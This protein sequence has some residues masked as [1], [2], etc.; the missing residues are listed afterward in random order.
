MAA[1]HLNVLLTDLKMLVKIS[2]LYSLFFCMHTGN[3]PFLKWNLYHQG[4]HIIDNKYLRPCL[5]DN[6]QHPNHPSSFNTLAEFV[7]QPY[8]PNPAQIMFDLFI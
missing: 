4:I 3:E 8:E 6:H 2:Y 7:R 1:P 5:K